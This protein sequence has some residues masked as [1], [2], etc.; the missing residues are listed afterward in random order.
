MNSKLDF[1]TAVNETI[2]TIF[3]YLGIGIAFGI[4]GRTLGFSLIEVWLTSVLVYAGSAQFTLL[5]MLAAGSSF[6]PIILAVFLINSRMILMSMSIAPHFKNASLKENIL[7]GTFL[8]DESFALGMNKLNYTNKTMNFSWFNTANLIS[9]LTWIVATALGESLASVIRNPQKFGFD[10]AIVAMFL[11][12][13]YLQVISDHQL[14]KS[15]Q[16]VV[17]GITCLV[18]YCGM[19][20]LPSNYVVIV[21]SLMGCI[22]GVGLKN[23]I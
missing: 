20:F 15:L 18:T 5:A 22:S 9:Y 21:A 16:V 1:R 10:F 6:L 4:I 23:V 13:L 11:G 2:P 12:L 3:G 8:T 7:I 17:I 19:I 14:K